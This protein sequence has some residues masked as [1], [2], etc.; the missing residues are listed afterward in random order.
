M[1]ET[2]IAFQLEFTAVEETWIRKEIGSDTT[3]ELLLS[4]MK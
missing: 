1:Q 3:K 2:T 4:H